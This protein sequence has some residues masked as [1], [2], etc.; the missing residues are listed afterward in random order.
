MV[1]AEGTDASDYGSGS[2]DDL[3]RSADQNE[4]IDRYS[5]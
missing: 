2:I 1:G 3:V 4:W 5:R